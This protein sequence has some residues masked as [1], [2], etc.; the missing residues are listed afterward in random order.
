MGIK[1]LLTFFLVWRILLFIFLFFALYYLPLQ[2]NFLGGGLENYLEK[3]YLWAWANFD[4]EHFLAIAKEGYR[5]LT[6]FFFPVY[7]ILTRLFAGLIGGS[8]YSYLVSGLF[9]SHSAFFIGLMGLV[10]LI[11]LDYK[12]NI[13]FLTI[14]LVLLFPTSFYFASVYSESLFLALSVWTFYFARKKRWVLV[15]LLGAI[16]SATRIVGVALFPALVV[17]ALIQAKEKKTHLFF[18]IVSPFCVL[19]GLITYATFLR[20]DAGDPLAFFNSLNQVFGEQ[21]S[22][23]LIFL[24]QVFYRY[25]FKIL[26]N[27]NYS[28]FPVVFSTWFEFLVAVLFGGLGLLGILALRLHHISYGMWLRSGSSRIFELAKIRSSYTVYLVLGYLIP[29]LTGSFSSLP[30]YV[31][32]LFPGF[33]LMAVYLNKL[34]SSYRYFFFAILFILL[35]I[36]TALFVRGY[37]IA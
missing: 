3:P 35:G 2:K 4:G 18:P 15:G 36:A 12:G 27:I 34:K 25:I 33:I 23:I 21:R 26:P 1:K 10:R 32:I 8:F 31:L 11:R 37:W 13:V 29:T 30:R 24:P 6:Y 14:I 7:P 28:Y 17:E 16:A 5:P 22:Q 9:L 20:Q 19:L